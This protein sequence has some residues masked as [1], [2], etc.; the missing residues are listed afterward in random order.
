MDN[1]RKKVSAIM[2]DNGLSLISIGMRKG[3][4]EAW[5]RKDF[6]RHSYVTLSI[7]G[8][9]VPIKLTDRLRVE[10]YLEDDEGDLHQTDVRDDLTLS[11]AMEIVNHWATFGTV[12]PQSRF[13]SKHHLRRLLGR[14]GMGQMTRFRVRRQVG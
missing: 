4:C 3:R 9:E 14:R 1:E 7:D 2:R 11:D 8:T 10:T 12:D 13:P 5:W 6:N